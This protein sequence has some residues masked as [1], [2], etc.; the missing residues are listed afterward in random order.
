MTRSGRRVTLYRVRMPLKSRAGIVLPSNSII[1]LGSNSILGCS[2]TFLHGG[3]Q[4]I[5]L[6]NRKCFR[7]RGGPRG[8]FV[9]RTSSVGIGMLNAIFG[10]HSCPRSSRVRIDL[11]GKEM[12]MFSTSRAQSGIVLTPSRRLACSGEDNGVGRRR[13]STLRASR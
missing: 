3:D 1:Y 7:M 9:I 5:C 6:V 2:P 10:I 4:R 12:G 8:P 11:V 13:M